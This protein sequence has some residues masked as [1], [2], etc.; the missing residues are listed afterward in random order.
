V[1][2]FVDR[3]ATDHAEF[4]DRG[5]QFGVEHLSQAFSESFRGLHETTLPA[6]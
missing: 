3:D 2:A 1:A 5:A 6:N 4:D